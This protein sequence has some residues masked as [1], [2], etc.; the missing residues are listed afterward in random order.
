MLL[1]AGLLTVYTASFAV[2]YLEYGDANHFVVRQGIYAIAGQQHMI[3]LFLQPVLEHQSDILI[4]VYYHN[5]I[6]CHLPTL[7]VM[8]VLLIIV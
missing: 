6:C 3:A 8:L 4:V 5:P 2:G 7:D 1:L